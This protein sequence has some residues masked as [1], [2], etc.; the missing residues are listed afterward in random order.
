[1][2]TELRDVVVLGRALVVLCR[3]NVGE[4]AVALA[5]DDRARRV[6][7]LPNGTWRVAFDSEDA[8]FAGAIRGPQEVQSHGTVDWPVA[9]PGAWVFV[10]DASSTSPARRQ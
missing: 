8:R 1:M 2:C 7:P 9:G 4:A 10:R 6:L 3:S 5:F